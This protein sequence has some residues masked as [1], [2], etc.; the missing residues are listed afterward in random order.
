MS[1]GKT[2]K[3]KEVRTMKYDMTV[4]ELIAL[5]NKVEDKNTTVNFHPISKRAYQNGVVE[6]T[7]SEYT[8]TT[9]ITIK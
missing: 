9:T 5:L 2:S 3:R 1:G 7:T 4:A 8:K 6:I